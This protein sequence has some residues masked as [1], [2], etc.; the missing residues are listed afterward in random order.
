MKSFVFSSRSLFLCCRLVLSPFFSNLSAQ[1]P[2]TPPPAAPS[3]SA[4]PTAP[5]PVLDFGDSKSSTLTGK[6]WGAFR[7]K[8]YA[9]A[10]GYANKCIEL[11][12]AEAVGQQSNL[13]EA[14]PKETAAQNWALNDVGTCYFVLGKALDQ[15]GNKKD[16]ITAYK[17]LVDNLSIAQCRAPKGWF[18]QPAAGAKLRM[19]ELHFDAQ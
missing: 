11:Y 3:D 1:T 4:A 12:K 9:A 5:P 8:N 2:A 10:E 18:W 15:E 14:A 16:A 19:A 13:K 7:A 6:A 17:F